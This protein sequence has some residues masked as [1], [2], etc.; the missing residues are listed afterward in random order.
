MSGARIDIGFKDVGL[1]AKSY[2]WVQTVRTSHPIGHEPVYND[3]PKNDGKPFYYSEG[4]LPSHT[5]RN[6]MDLTFHDKP[7]R[8]SSESAHWQG[9]LSLVGDFGAGHT[10]IVTFRYGFD[11]AQGRSWVAPPRATL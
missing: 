5:N 11:V 7:L 8:Y 9:E 3:G 2:R 4:Q 6:G 1:N 10:E